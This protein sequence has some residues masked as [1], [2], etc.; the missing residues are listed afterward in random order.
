MQCFPSLR[1]LV[2]EVKDLNQKR[3]K[4]ESKH[5]KKLIFNVKSK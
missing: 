5:S 4:A 3:K 1:D 2:F